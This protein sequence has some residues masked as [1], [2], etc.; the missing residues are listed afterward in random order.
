M[1]V[2]ICSYIAMS[3]AEQLSL[4]LFLQN[5]TETVFELF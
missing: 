1:Y 2:F 5:I 4:F 3:M